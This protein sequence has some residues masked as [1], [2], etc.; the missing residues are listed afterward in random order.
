MTL[1]RVDRV[2]LLIAGIV[3]GMLIVG[4]LVIGCL[5]KGEPA[6]SPALNVKSNGE[7]ASPTAGAKV[8]APF[9][10][11]GIIQ[12]VHYAYRPDGADFEGGGDTFTVR[13]N[14]RGAF[15]MTPLRFEQTTADADR[16]VPQRDPMARMERRRERM[17]RPEAVRGTPA[18]FE[19]TGIVRGGADL[20]GSP[21]R[22][23]NPDDGAWRSG[24]LAQSSG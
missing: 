20:G 15:A 1:R 4:G 8:S 17:E 7:P 6:A 2:A 19:T 21:V 16:G 11:S 18:T 9:D 24:G 12:Q 5:T 10:L 3:L 23:D 13:V 14:P 22:I